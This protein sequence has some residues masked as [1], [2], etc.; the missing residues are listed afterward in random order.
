MKGVKT[1]YSVKDKMPESGK[2]VIFGWVNSLGKRRT[3]IGFYAAPKSID[4]DDYDEPTLYEYDE[5]KDGYWLHE[6]WYEE[7]AEYE[8]FYPIDKVVTHWTDIPIWPVL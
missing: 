3:S 6:G 5:E 8:Y 2:R 1:M 7:G 4:A